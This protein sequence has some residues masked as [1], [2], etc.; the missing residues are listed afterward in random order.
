MP[1]FGTAQHL[2]WF[3]PSPVSAAGPSEG[4]ADGLNDPGSRL[5]EAFR[6]RQRPRDGM[7]HRLALLG[8][9]ALG[10]VDDGADEPRDAAVGTGKGG[11]VLDGIPLPATGPGTGGFLGLDALH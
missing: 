2:R 8:L 7:L 1:C 3:I 11:L 5:A 9:L 6:F 10:D 4:F